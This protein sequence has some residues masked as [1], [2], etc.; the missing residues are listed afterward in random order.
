MFRN[1]TPYLALLI[2]L[3][4]PPTVLAR[5]TE[6]GWSLPKI[7]QLD[8]SGRRELGPSD[9]ISPFR[10]A[11]S[12]TT[13]YGGTFWAADSMRWEAYENQ[14]WTFDTGVGSSIVPT[15][16]A[17][18]LSV[19]TSNWVNPFKRA[20]LH[21]TMEGW[22][23]YDQTVSTTYPSQFRR[24]A[25]GDP[26]WQGTVCVGA[27]AGLQGNY[28]YW[29]GILA[30]E[31]DAL[32]YKSGQGYGNAWN[33]CIEH[34]FNY[35]GGNVTLSFMYKNETENGFDYTH[36]Y[37][38]T[39]GAGNLSHRVEVVVFTGTSSG[40]FELPLTVG[41]NLPRVPKPI[42][43][44][45]C[46]VSD[47]LWSDQDGLY[48]T[49][50]GA[51]ALDNIVLIGGITYLANFETGDDGW[52]LSPPEPGLGG[53]WSSLYS[54]NDLPPSLASC[55]CA[56]SDSVLAFPDEYSQH[57]NY[58]DN[59]AASPWI[60][61]KAYG[62]VGSAGKIIKTNIY[63][64]LPLRNYIFAQFNAQWYPEKCPETGKLV[65]SSW[66]SNGFVYY[67]GGVPQCT[68]V[69]PG[70][71]GT[72]IDFSAVIP[73]GAEQVRIALGC[74]SYCRFFAECTQV[75]NTTP[76]FDF[77]GL[78]VYG[79]PDD[80][81]I[82]TNDA[83]RAQDSF[84][85]DGTINL[86][87]TGR[88]DCN[89]SPFLTLGD[90][91]VVRSATVDAEVYVHFRVTPGPGI[92]M[93]NL[94]SWYMSHAVSPIDPGYRVARCDSAERGSSGPITGY[95]MTS[96]H[97][98][99]PNFA[100]HGVNDRTLDASDIAPNGGQWHLSH[101][102][103][104][105]HLMTAGT[106]IDY[107]FSA[108]R[109]GSSVSRMDPPDAP[110]KAYEME[111]L[112]AMDSSNKTY[113]CVLYVEHAGGYARQLI[114]AGLQSVLGLGPGNFEGTRWDRYD[115]GTPSRNG[116]VVG[117]PPGW[118]HGATANQLLSAYR[119]ILWD[120]G[121]SPT[122]L[123]YSDAA[124]LIPWLTESAF[125]YNRLYLSG[126][127]IVYDAREGLSQQLIEHLAGVKLKTPC[128]FQ[129]QTCSYGSTP[130]DL[131]LC[132]NLR[133]MPRAPVAN[134]GPGRSVGH[135]AQ[136]N[137]CPELRAFHILDVAAPDYGISLGDE[138]YVS[139]MKFSRF[140]SVATDAAPSGTLHYKMVTE[141][142]SL[143]YRRDEG[144]PCDFATGGRTAITERLREVL[145]YF[146]FCPQRPSTGV[147]GDDQPPAPTLLLGVASNPLRAGTM[148]RIRFSMSEDAPARVDIVD[149]Q[150]R[151]VKSVFD[152]PAKKGLNEATWDGRDAGGSYVASG[153]YF[154]RFRA[155]DQDQSRKLVIVGGRN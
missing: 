75:S 119:V 95:W 49:A 9:F 46:V 11:S 113:N 12:G 79:K 122:P 68:S 77:A 43:I 84:P 124:V 13:F 114:E 136:G 110:A 47:G 26:R 76:W 4:G 102:I 37:V 133:P 143:I 14:L 21:A 74:L 50:C 54:L 17:G 116:V 28:S 23:G 145:S 42:R 99:D 82:F 88:I 126:N 60:D 81:L 89:E 8:A 130:S 94:N 149:L 62:K 112:P 106:H 101:D 142:L 100:A 55:A 6:D 51:F 31:A 35:P 92:N 129:Y 83:G 152:A 137:G 78:G 40:T 59:L 71:I 80:N 56:L 45:F 150:G 144:T 69:L 73:P 63:S 131:T 7:Q 153:V 108:N 104:P 5:P 41:R 58:T 33:I 148:G 86:G 25:G 141:G 115:V 96:Y 85:E 44:Q 70:T 155:L 36:V 57:N 121:D 146:D 18:Q 128:S 103:F 107:F 90:S 117:R 20:G 125:D 24:L 19:P 64:D 66:T 29:A 118:H 32:C 97:E 65:T 139:P 10:T 27:A 2:P 53:E 135:V 147:I 38:D 34:A 61:L 138:M 127:W 3:F 109:V 140:A 87:A 111:I 15:G 48:P 120:S 67:Y 52:T 16:G 123:A 132:P 154:Y 1:P 98:S 93:T 72:Q 22:I 39:S 30:D 91:L 151:V 105:D 134:S